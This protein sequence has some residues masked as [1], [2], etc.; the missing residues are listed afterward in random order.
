MLKKTRP[1][2]FAALPLMAFY[3]TDL[4]PV[5]YA[6]A[7]KHE[8]V[9]IIERSRV[10]PVISVPEN[11]TPSLKAA[12]DD[13]ASFLNGT[14]G[15]V[16]AKIVTGDVKGPA[17]VIRANPKLPADGFEIKTAQRNK[18]YIYGNNTGSSKGMEWGIY[19]FS[20]RVLGVRKYF[21]EA[22]GGTSFIKRQSL[23]VKPFS[24]SDSPRFEMRVIW[25]DAGA[26][27]GG[28]KRV[29]TD[30]FRF[31]RTNNLHGVQLKVHAPYPRL[32]ITEGYGKSSP[33]IFQLRSNGTRDF[34]MLCYGNPGTLKFYID[35]IKEERAG[36]R[37]SHFIVGNAVT[38]SPA[39]AQVLCSCKDCR[40]LFD[41]ND[42]EAGTSSKIMTCFVRKL[43]QAIAEEYPD[44]TVIYLAYLNYVECPP[45]AKFRGNVEVQVCSMPGLALF[46]EPS[47]RSREQK[48][49][50]DWVKATGRKIQNWHYLCWPEDRTA[51][52]YLFPNTILSH[53]K[54][55]INKSFG[56]F[57]NGMDD[58]SRQNI[59]IYFWMKALWNPEIN[60]K[61]VLDSYA[62]R[63][64]GLAAKPMRE[65]VQMQ[66]DGWEKNLWKNGKMSA[67][68]M[69][70]ESF[71][72]RDVVKMEALLKEAFKLAGKDQLVL[73]RL[74]YYAE[75]FADFFRESAAFA[76][77]KALRP[78]MLQKA[79]NDPI[80]DGKLDDYAWKNAEPNEFV[81]ALDKKVSK[82]VFPTAVQA[83]W[84]PRGVTFGFRL[85]EPTPEKL[86][87]KHS[88]RDSGSLWWNDN[89]EIF[90]DVSGNGDGDFYQ[91]IIDSCGGVYDAHNDNPAW[92]CSGLK[93]A[94]FKGKDFWSLE[95]FIPYS[96]F[97]KGIFPTASANG[98]KW[99]G[100]FTRHRVADSKRTEAEYTR[101]NTT[102]K[103]GSNNLSDF[104]DFKFIE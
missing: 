81:R 38:V 30:F 54:N 85:S 91:F 57:I 15:S 102:Y 51:V 8:N 75:P 44:M 6:P 96:A 28:P 92:N 37:K 100:N 9:R 7:P 27:R 97:K 33:E 84:T 22:Y 5:K 11:L 83:V 93:S 14:S 39:D 67:K 77:G 43:S 4:S 73:K 56:S 80:I 94:S 1:L 65:L 26:K 68:S 59:S 18:I 62:E 31:L 66:I 47:I 16:T 20:E 48:I 79:G 103:S 95:V 45:N 13:L 69:Y 32:L 86:M 17:I 61:A 35:R 53:Y 72:R 49:I 2:L 10:V 29:F 55:N 74:N 21:P 23:E 34:E 82:P 63:M 19:D 42:G 25:P 3:D 40:K 89:I 98:V 76:S 50:D 88:G 46:K 99:M 90:I 64:Y 101:M 104:A 24:Y 60:V 36:G 71:P 41:P 70:T 87:T 78:L 12:V 58:H 52:P